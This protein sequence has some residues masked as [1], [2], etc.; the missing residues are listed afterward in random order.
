METLETESKAEE[1]RLKTTL[2][3]VED[4]LE[5]VD[6]F[7]LEKDDLEAHQKKTEKTLKMLKI[8]QV[9]EV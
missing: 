6:H 1:N 4:Q 8:H 5:A 9:G 3:E 2:K 7:L